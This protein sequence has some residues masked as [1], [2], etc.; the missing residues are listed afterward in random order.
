MHAKIKAIEYF[1]PELT[2]TTAD[3][4]RQFPGHDCA[5]TD[6]KTGIRVRH[7]AS[8][9]EC[10]S[11]LACAAARKLFN[12]GRCSP[13]QVDFLILC[14]QT[15]DYLTPTTACLLQN[16][17]GLSTTTGALD[18]NLGCSGFVYGLGLAEGLITSGQASG[19]L[20]ITADTYS[21]FMNPRDRSARA[22]FGDAAA[23]T[24]LCADAEPSP[25]IGP[26][27]FG[28]DGRGSSS[29]IVP[30][31]GLRCQRSTATAQAFTDKSGNLR[32]GDDLHM[33]GKR[34]MDFVLDVV[35]SAVDSLLRKAAV[36]KEDVGLY[37]FHQAN[38]YLLDFLRESMKIEPDKLQVTMAHCGNTVSSSIPIA[39][40]HAG[41]E[42]RLKGDTQ[43]LVVGFGVGY[44]WG[45][46]IIRRPF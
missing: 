36:T 42:G 29:F 35:P 23:A 28:T 27:V 12:S 34:M 22:I 19:V 13:K 46:T 26:F 11:D 9:D 30:S 10:A 37:I 21:K 5:R 44:S 33:D 20:F 31:S 39:L 2:V 6:A 43:V 7:V 17:L 45:A 8:S 18:I 25:S 32:S 15:P 4:C 41:Q 14:T 38:A 40:W 24:F 3:L 16:R 1:L